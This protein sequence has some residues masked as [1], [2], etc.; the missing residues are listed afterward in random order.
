MKAKIFLCALTLCACVL[1]QTIYAGEYDMGI[2]HGIAVDTKIQNAQYIAVDKNRLINEFNKKQHSRYKDTAVQTPIETK[3]GIDLDNWTTPSAPRQNFRQT[4]GITFGN[5][6]G[7][8]MDIWRDN[9]QNLNGGVDARE[10]QY[11]RDDFSE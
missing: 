1:G 5:S 7:L 10:T 11:I 4:D 3:Y 2:Q 8:D 9:Y 6:R